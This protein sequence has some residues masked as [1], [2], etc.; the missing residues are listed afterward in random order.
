[1]KILKKAFQ[2]KS[3]TDDLQIAISK[4]KVA[5][6]LLNMNKRDL[7]EAVHEKE[8]LINRILLKEFNYIVESEDVV[9]FL[10]Q[11]DKIYIYDVIDNK[12]GNENV[13]NGS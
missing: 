5:Y 9:L 8:E 11:L 4:I 10:E 12:D 3:N 7:I 6:T 2:L 13:F 1:M